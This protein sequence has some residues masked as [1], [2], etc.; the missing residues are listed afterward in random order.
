[1]KERR[2]TSTKWDITTRI[3]L[4]WIVT[5]PCSAFIAALVLFAITAM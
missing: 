4:A 2:L 5:I 1:M 3:V